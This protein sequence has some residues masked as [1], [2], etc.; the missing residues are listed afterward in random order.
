MVKSEVMEALYMQQKR[1]DN[2]A[3]ISLKWGQIGRIDEVRDTKLTS[4][5]WTLFFFFFWENHG[6]EL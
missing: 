1:E 2:T 6:Y 4:R 5:L 3:N